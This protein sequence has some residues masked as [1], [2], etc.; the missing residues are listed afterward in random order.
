MDYAP[1]APGVEPVDEALVTLVARE[2]SG[3]KTLAALVD[4][5]TPPDIGLATSRDR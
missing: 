5:S 4:E 2:L 1:I 3:P